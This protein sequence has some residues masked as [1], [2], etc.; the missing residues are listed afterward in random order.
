MKVLLRKI[1]SFLLNPLE[2]GD[3]PYAYKSLH[4]KVLV[5]VG[6]LFSFL[7][8]V[9]LMMMPPDAEKGYFLPV[10]IFGAVAVV[11]MVVAFLGND[12]AVS[13]LWGSRS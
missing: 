2:R 12:R 5:A 9:V 4:R 13:K 1:F 7:A 3:E 11:A 6:V 10:I 8:A